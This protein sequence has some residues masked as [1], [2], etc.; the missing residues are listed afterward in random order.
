MIGQFAHQSASGNE[1]AVLYLPVL[2]LMLTRFHYLLVGAACIFFITTFSTRGNLLAAVVKI[3]SCKLLTSKE[4]NR[5][6]VLCTRPT[7]NCDQPNT[8]CH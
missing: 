5:V 3:R 8:D 7:N 6:R 2:L 1:V 4:K